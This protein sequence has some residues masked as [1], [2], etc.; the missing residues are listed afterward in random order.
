MSLKCLTTN[1]DS[2]NYPYKVLRVIKQV[3]QQRQLFK[4]PNS[5]SYINISDFS[6]AQIERRN[7]KIEVEYFVENP[8]D[9]GDRKKIELSEDGFYLYIGRLSEEKGIRLFCEVVNQLKLKAVVIGDG[10]LKE[11]M[12]ARYGKNIE[13]KGWLPKEDIQNY[14]MR[15][16]CLIFT[17]IWY[18]TF[19]LTV[20]EAISAGVPCLVPDNCSAAD[21]ITDE[22]NGLIYKSGDKVSLVDT[23]R[24]M[25]NI[26]LANV[27]SNNAFESFDTCRYSMET[28][29]NKLLETYQGVLN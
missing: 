13:F 4:R 16:R 23:I 9:I 12:N 22:F 20:L 27:I 11:E 25:Q 5:I 18:E 28:H 6:K 2:R 14:F 8:I 24:Q 15:S 26:D 19:G 21:F 17:S 29:L 3:I 7:K 1:C 10:P